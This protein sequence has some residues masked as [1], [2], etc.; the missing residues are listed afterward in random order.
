[1]PFISEEI[2]IT[3][4]KNVLYFGRNKNYWGRNAVNFGKY[5]L[6]LGKRMAIN[7]EIKM[8][9]DLRPACGLNVDKI[10][11]LV[12]VFGGELRKALLDCSSDI[13]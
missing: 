3:S 11:G 5:C 10:D 7:G 6:N 2:A 4:E 12:V 1:M 8:P 13:T 9:S